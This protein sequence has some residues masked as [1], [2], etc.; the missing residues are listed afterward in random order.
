MQ[1]KRTGWNGKR[2]KH[3]WN[4]SKIL[5]AANAGRLVQA[6]H[7]VYKTAAAVSKAAEKSIIEANQAE[8]R[9]R[10]VRRKAKGAA[11]KAAKSTK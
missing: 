7:A 5:A 6:M 9:A 2:S 10:K 3:C 1:I 11:K 4:A 8:E